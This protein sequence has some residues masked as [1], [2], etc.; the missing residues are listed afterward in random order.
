MIFSAPMVRA[1]LREAKAPG[2]GKAQT[3]RLLKKAPEGGDWHCDRRRDDWWFVASPGTPSFPAGVRFAVGDRLWVKEAFA[4]EYHKA[5]RGLH[6]AFTDYHY[7]ATDADAFMPSMRWT[8]PL[9]LPREG[10]R[11]TLVV[12]A[13]RV[14]RLQDITERDALAEGMTWEAF[15]AGDA[16]GDDP[17]DAYRTLW[18][19]LHGPVAWAENPWIVALTFAVTAANID[20][21]SEAA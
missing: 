10:S 15:K 14:E 18:R 3:R 17:V 13:V 9:F 1:L 11:L 19:E 21:K 5:Q 12:H 8:S 16:K 2:T 7:R 6:K 4:V 20:A